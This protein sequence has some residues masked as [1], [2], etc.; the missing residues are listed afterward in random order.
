MSSFVS[1][2]GPSVTMHW[3]PESRI[4]VLSAVGRS[5]ATS[6]S[7]PARFSSSRYFITPTMT[8]AAGISPASE[9]LLA[10]T[11]IKNLMFVSPPPNGGARQEPHAPYC[12]TAG[13]EIDTEGGFSHTLTP[14]LDGSPRRSGAGRLVAVRFSPVVS[15]AS[16]HN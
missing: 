12:R 4:R 3:P 13:A 1:T 7:T 11:N 14:D 16:W 15:Q 10:F 6:T 2:N 5:A 8:S 9:A